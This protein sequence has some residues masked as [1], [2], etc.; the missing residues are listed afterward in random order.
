MIDIKIIYLKKH[1]ITYS[2]YLKYLIFGYALEV[3]ALERNC[4]IDISKKCLC[5]LIYDQ[6]NKFTFITF[7]FSLN[8]WNLPIYKQLV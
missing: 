7:L 1:F 2:T 8:I 4:D 3:C 6:Y 5:I